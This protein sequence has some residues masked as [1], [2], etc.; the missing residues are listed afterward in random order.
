MSENTTQSSSNA[1][2]FLIK[3]IVASAL[4]SLL[5]KYGG[6]LLPIAAPY[7]EELNGLVTAIIITPSLLIGVLLVLLL[8][9]GRSSR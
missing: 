7:T 1:A 9:K 4:L 8:T 3:V 2:S 5:L 6:Q